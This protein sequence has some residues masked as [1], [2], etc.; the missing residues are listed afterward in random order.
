MAATPQD[1][2]EKLRRWDA[3][4]AGIPGE[5]W[6]TFV[7]GVG[8]WV[9]TRRHPSM[10]VRLVAGITAGLLVARAAAG[11]QIPQTLEHLV[12]DS[13]WLH[14]KTGSVLPRKA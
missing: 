10:G 14:R 11:R 4:R 9:A 8:L 13:S 3:Q 6:I 2:L 7:A 5:H 1:Y 12:P